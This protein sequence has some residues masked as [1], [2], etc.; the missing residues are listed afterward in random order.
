MGGTVAETIRKKD[1][2]VIKMA[3]KT[4]AYNWMFF[5]N[6]FLTG[7]IDKAIDEHIL[8]FQQMQED[9]YSGKPYKYPMTAVYGG[10]NEIA[11]HSYGLVVID[12]QKN[13][14][15]SMQGYDR[16]FTMNLLYS[17]YISD[18]EKKNIFNAYK[19]D[20]LDVYCENKFLMPFKDFLNQFSFT[21]S[22]G[23]NKFFEQFSQ[24][25]NQREKIQKLSGQ[26]DAYPWDIQIRPNILTME[27][28]RYEENI[29][30]GTHMFE[31]LLKDGF[32]FSSD[33][34]QTWKDFLFDVDLHEN[35]CTLSEEEYYNTSDEDLDKHCEANKKSMIKNFDNLVSQT[36]SSRYQSKS[37]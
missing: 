3:R 22:K 20:L 33:E 13:K 5:S 32:E 28:I 10:F 9:F 35:F 12:F 17:T 4:G 27:V 29:E 37:F 26:E 6:D 16:P 14:I 31:A 2:R 36:N 30:G 19:N 18:D 34:I 11:P 1:G 24:L 15:H 7:N 25:S 8:A 23:I 21:D